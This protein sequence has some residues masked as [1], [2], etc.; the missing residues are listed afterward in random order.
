MLV[1]RKYR[2][3]EKNDI[4]DLL[5][6]EKIEDLEIQDFIYVMLE[7]DTVI[8]AC[9]VDLEGEEGFLSYLVIESNK[10]GEG[11]GEGLLRAILNKLDLDGILKV[12][13][14]EKN[15]YLLSKGFI[16]NGENQLELNLSEFFSG[17]CGC[18]GGFNEI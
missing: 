18:L 6:K 11:L 16:E 17:S 13:F 2:E 8:G 5:I 9:K 3:N 12:Y 7:D 10:R 14:H 4:R 1:M 15:S